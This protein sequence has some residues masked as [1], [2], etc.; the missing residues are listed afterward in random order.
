MPETLVHTFGTLTI[1]TPYHFYGK[2]F[3]QFNISLYKCGTLRNLVP[4]VQFK[5]REKQPR[6]C[7]TFSSTKVTKSNKSNTL[8]WVFSTFLIL[9]KWY[10]IAQSF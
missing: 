2:K 3:Q 7:V 8:P 6:R 9:H 5:K 1:V 10:Q 4:Y